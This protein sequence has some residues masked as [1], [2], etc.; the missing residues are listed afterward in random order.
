[1]SEIQYEAVIGL[2]VHVQAET[3]S[4]MFTRVARGFGEPPNTLTDPV[5]LG[6]PGALPSV[7]STVLLWIRAATSYPA[8][9]VLLQG[10]V[11]PL[12]GERRGQ[13]DGEGFFGGVWTGCGL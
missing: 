10:A 2:E 6:L 4:K 9:T 12:T 13:G 1:M 8:P 3:R 7:V 11:A 5:V